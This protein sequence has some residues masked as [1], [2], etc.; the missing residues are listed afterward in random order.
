MMMKRMVLC[1]LY[2]LCF[3][4]VHAGYDRTIGPGSDYFG[5]LDWNGGSL[6]VDGG[7]GVTIS[8]KDDAYL[9]VWSTSSPLEL[10]I[11]GIQY[12]DLTNTS[13]LDY[14]GG[15]TFVLTL[16]KDATATLSGGRI[17]VMQ[18]L[19]LSGKTKHITMIC[20]VDSV[21]YNVATRVLTGNWLD[22]SPFSTT[23][24][25]INPFDSTYSNI[26]FVPEP[27]TLL[28]L[29]LGSLLIRQRK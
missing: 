7:G 21:N 2:V 8:L 18:S 3:S 17:D 26:L 12:I 24:V 14:S 9:A 20:D 13:H 22:G 29:G 16:Q 23:L 4:V 11:G 10:G 19:Q 27:T 5:T 28:L 25:N 6:L 1:L 15:E